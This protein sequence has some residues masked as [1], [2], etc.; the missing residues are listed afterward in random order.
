MDDFVDLDNFIKIE[1]IG[2]GSFG[3]VLKV[4][5]K[6]TGEIYAAKIGFKS[7]EEETK[8]AKINLAREVNLLSQLNHPSILKFIG[9]SP[10]NFDKKNKPI[11]ITEYSS[12]GS[13]FDILEF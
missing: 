5:D 10:Y 12:T 8:D 6:Q 11:I 13:L 2:K 7:L 1:K 3:E 9:Y 4:K